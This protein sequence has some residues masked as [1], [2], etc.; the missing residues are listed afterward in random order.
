MKAIKFKDIPLLFVLIFSFASS[1]L[2]GCGGGGGAGGN[3]GGA[4][5]TGNAPVALTSG[6]QFSFTGGYE[7]FNTGVVASFIGTMTRQL[8]VVSPTSGSY[9]T[10][11]AGQTS[12][13]S[14]TG[15]G[16]IGYTRIDANSAKIV[17]NGYPYLTNNDQVAFGVIEI[18]LTYTSP[19]AGSYTE[20]SITTLTPYTAI[21]TFTVTSP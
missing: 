6:S 10:T 21:G 20:I 18:R 12:S 17:V 1:F 16:T 15:A 19:T 9:Q 13:G 5:A 4:I 7:R 14:A 8:A 11:Y 3:N 2:M